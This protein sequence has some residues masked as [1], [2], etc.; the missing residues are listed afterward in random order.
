MSG[1][2]RSKG[3]IRGDK[4]DSMRKRK[5]LWIFTFLL[6]VTVMAAIICFSSQSAAESNGL[7]K[8][9]AQWLLNLVPSLGDAVTLRKLNHFLRKSAH[10]SLYFLLGC[11]LTGLASRQRKIPPVLLAVLGGAAFAA[12]DE[13]HQ[14]FSDGRGPMLQDVLLDTCGVTAGALFIALLRKVFKRFSRSDQ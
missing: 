7:S 4:A 9:L 14:F 3:S 6:T 10:F 1:S 13:F 8:G 12:A 11:G 5:G 2:E